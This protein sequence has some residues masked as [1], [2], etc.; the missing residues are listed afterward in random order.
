MC[1]ASYEG[2]PLN[3]QLYEDLCENHEKYV[4][5]EQIKLPQFYRYQPPQYYKVKAKKGQEKTPEQYIEDRSYFENFLKQK[6]LYDTWPRTE[7]GH[8]SRDE[9]VMLDYAI[10]PEIAQYH[11]AKKRIKQ[12]Q[13]FR[14]DKE[15]GQPQIAKYVTCQNGQLRQRPD[16]GT[17]GTTTSRNAHRTVSFI[18]GM[19]RRLRA[20]LLGCPPDCELVIA[21]YSAQEVWIAGALSEDKNQLKASKIDP[22]LDFAI[23]NGLAPQGATKHSHG[24]IREVCKSVVLAAFYGMG[25]K[26]LSRKI[27]KS[28]FETKEIYAKNRAYYHQFFEWQEKFLIN[29]KDKSYYELKD[30]WPLFDNLDHNGDYK[31]CPAMNF[32]I[33]GHGAVIMRKVVD[34]FSQNNVRLIYTL[35]DEFA[36]LCYKE[37]KENTKQL[38]ERLMQEACSYYFPDCEPPRVGFK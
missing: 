25:L 23:A 20:K 14:K 34:L 13:F 38:I 10:I 27:Q 8:C 6:D 11:A 12:I 9:R 31:T 26:S 24:E 21:D 7:T 33:Q 3:K 35:H 30:G 2:V 17:F 15:T 1:C 28:E 22:Y 18:M 19:E 16:C 37:D 5:E 4:K 36:V 32:P 29:H